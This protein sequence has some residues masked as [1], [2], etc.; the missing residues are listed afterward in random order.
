MSVDGFASLIPPGPRPRTPDAPQ[1]VPEVLDRT[2]ADAPDREF[3]VG[4]SGRMTYAEF[5]AAA[6]RCAHHLASLGVGPRDMITILQAIKYYN[7]NDC[8]L[9]L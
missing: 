6:N 9:D 4:R 1:I 2:L 7:L 5:D 8:F 3:V